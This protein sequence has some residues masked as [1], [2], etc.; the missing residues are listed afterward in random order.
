M[1]KMYDLTVST[2]DEFWQ[3]MDGLLCIRE[4]YPGEA[5]KLAKELCLMWEDKKKELQELKD[6]N[7]I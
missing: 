2:G 6:K 1:R 3:K 4:S 5:R 7:A